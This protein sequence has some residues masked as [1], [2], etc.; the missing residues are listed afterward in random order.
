MY[1]YNWNFKDFSDKALL[2]RA[3][4]L[5]EVIDEIPDKATFIDIDQ[6]PDGRVIV[7]WGPASGK[8]TAIRQYL[9]KHQ[10]DY[11]IFATAKKSDVDSMYYDLLAMQRAGY[12]VKECIISKFHSNYDPGETELRH[13]NILVCTHERLMIEPPSILYRLEGDI[14]N[15]VGQ[16][17]RSEMII[18]ELPKFYKSF[19]LDETM[20]M[21]LS[22]INES[23]L[24]QFEYDRRQRVAYRYS[25]F[26]RLISAY[27][28]NHWNELSPSEY[29]CVRGLIKSYQSSNISIVESCDR[30]VRKFAYFS[31]LLAE[32]LLELTKEKS[33]TE[34]LDQNLYYTLLDIEVPNIKI[35]DGTG[36]LILKGSNYWRNAASPKFPRSIRLKSHPIIL[37]DT[38]M[39]RKVTKEEEL[40]YTMDK[41]ENLLNHIRNILASTDGKL[42]LYTWKSIKLQQDYYIGEDSRESY[43]GD[44]P[45]YIRRS[46]TSEENE[47]LE[48]IY[49]GSGKER[50]TSE[51]SECDSIIIAGKFFIPNSAISS[52]NEVNSTNITS[53]DY[54]KALII[55][56]IYRTS[57]RQ[58]KP[59]TVYFTD[60]YS[61]SLVDSI[62]EKFHQIII[63]DEDC[64]GYYLLSSKMK[65]TS[66]NYRYYSHIAPYLNQLY[67]DGLVELT[68][69][70]DNNRSASS[71][72][73]FKLSI[74]RMI[75]DTPIKFE[76]IRNTNRFI[77]R[78][79][80][81]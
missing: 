14:S 62:M 17:I 69:P 49:Y 18:D 70:E 37:S 3:K 65:I 2:E 30:S 56:A 26:K 81:G 76:N 16:V 64:T 31:D 1:R 53:L 48:I 9:V 15:H 78:I 72:R 35:F 23:L 38:Q 60:D 80:K 5:V 4:Y 73:D 58:N 79:E 19:K 28:Q 45:D 33:Y 32:K 50:V 59:I 21:G 44:L 67:I 40:Q 43:L 77:L 51:Y 25:R 20:M 57:A 63:N 52:Y 46:L 6:L 8:S 55:Q 36:D 22:S 42:L 61:N 39:V 34:L 12:I 68:V 29:A 74:S 13:S 10:M 47:R 71:T 41:I 7:P 11:I 66:R 27:L 54:T 24:E 75:K